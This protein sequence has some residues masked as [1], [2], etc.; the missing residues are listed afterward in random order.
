MALRPVHDPF[1]TEG[2]LCDDDGMVRRGSM[3]KGQDF[4]CTGSAHPE[5]GVHIRCTNPRHY[6]QPYSPPAEPAVLTA[7]TGLA[8]D[9]EIRSYA[10]DAA[11]RL[12]SGQ[13]AIFQSKILGIAERFVEYIRDG[14]FDVDAPIDLRGGGR[15]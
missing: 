12:Y 4:V 11:A 15:G 6:T 5:S 7:L 2:R 1:T 13:G 10:L 3:H 8:V 14:R 9:Q